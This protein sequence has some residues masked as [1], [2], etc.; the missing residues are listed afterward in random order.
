MEENT[1]QMT[2]GG[3]EVLRRR[4]KKSWLVFFFFFWLVFLYKVEFVQDIS[5]SYLL[6]KKKIRL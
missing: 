1:G 2:A 3:K 6:K 4:F 5:Q